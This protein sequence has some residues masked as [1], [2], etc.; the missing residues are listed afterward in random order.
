[1]VD[2]KCIIDYIGNKIVDA[3]RFEKATGYQVKD[4]WTDE[5]ATNTSSSFSVTGIDAY[6]NVTLRITPVSGDDNV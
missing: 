5:L 6:D 4:L 2:V 3:S 1:M